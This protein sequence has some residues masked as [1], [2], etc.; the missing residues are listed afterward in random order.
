M[1]I[2]GA[3][4]ED[5]PVLTEYGEKFYQWTRHIRDGI[6]YNPDAVADLCNWL[7]D[8]MDAGFVLVLADADDVVKGF[9]LVAT[10]PFIFSPDIKVAGELAF[11]VDEDLRKTGF[12]RALMEHGEEVARQ[13][14]IRYMTLVAMETCMPDQ[15]AALYADM[16]YQKTE[17]TFV[18][19]L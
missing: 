12:G 3:R 4:I 1:K 2:R 5:I 18:K 10:S 9:L 7:I 15:V 17:T 8:N 13:N 19:E 16:G 14:G 6:P 11:Y